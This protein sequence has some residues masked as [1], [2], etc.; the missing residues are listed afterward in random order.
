[1]LPAVSK[2]LFINLILY[3]QNRNLKL[4]S[5]FISCLIDV[6]NTLTQDKPSYMQVNIWLK[7]VHTIGKASAIDAIVNIA[8]TVKLVMH[9][10]MLNVSLKHNTHLF[11]TLK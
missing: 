7:A 9:E 4:N 1:M 6:K 5:V 11:T 3:K 10:T 2:N 8:I